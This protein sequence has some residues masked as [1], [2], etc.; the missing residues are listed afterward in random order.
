MPADTTWRSPSVEDYIKVIY[1]IK[2]WQ[3]E[4]LT[5][6]QLATRVGVSAASASAMLRKLGERGLVH[7]VPYGDI[8]LTDAG[9]KL[10][11]QMLRRHRLIELYLVEALGYSWDEVHDE[12]EVLEHV[13]SDTFLDRIAER[14]G[15]PTHDPHGDPIPATDGSVPPAA[16]SPLA[17][18]EAGAAG[19]I[20]RVSDEDPD[21]LR[22]LDHSEVRLGD[23][24]EVVERQPFGG[25]L[26]VRIGRGAE[27]PVRPFGEKL[28][29]AVLVR[30]SNVG[31][32][33]AG[34]P[35]RG[36]G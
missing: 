5:T 25:P 36:V 10:A 2:E 7:H 34:P 22:Y 32:G 3:R 12:A 14:L 1:V 27:A 20:A 6:S 31:A 21:L 30:V 9:E 11:L 23:Q 17:D 8:A 29:R 35:H 26:L 16:T 18:L 4:S 19:V 24:V 15:W 28:A 33:V 13:V